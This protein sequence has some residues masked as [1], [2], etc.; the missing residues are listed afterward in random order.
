MA[1]K[2]KIPVREVK[3]L[4]IQVN[5]ISTELKGKI[6]LAVLDVVARIK[7]KHLS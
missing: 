5:P 3:H 4:H 7:E 2:L 6:K 1:E